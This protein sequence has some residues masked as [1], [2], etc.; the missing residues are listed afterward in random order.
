MRPKADQVA[1][2]VY[3]IDKTKNSTKKNEKI[4]ARYLKV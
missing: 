2:I 1:T 4:T 3:C